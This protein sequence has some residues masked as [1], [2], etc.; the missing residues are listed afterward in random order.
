MLCS[1]ERVADAP[2]DTI[3]RHGPGRYSSPGEH[4]KREICRM[5]HLSSED[6]A[7]ISVVVGTLEAR[8]AE[9]G[10]A[11]KI[12]HLWRDWTDLL[13]PAASGQ[14]DVALELELGE[15]TPPSARDS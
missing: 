3:S 11:S 15:V 7:S 10:P 8:L 1:D 9:L 2:Y 12:A 14:P 4:G 13:A 5:L 6:M